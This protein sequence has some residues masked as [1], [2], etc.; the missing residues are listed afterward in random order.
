[1]QNVTEWDEYTGHIESTNS[2]DIRA[3]VSGYL[4][5]VN[6]KAGSKVKKGDLLFEIDPKPFSA[7]LQYAQ[8]ELTASLSG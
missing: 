3:R 8:A 7:Q 4:Q 5:S 6:F 2:V 1:M